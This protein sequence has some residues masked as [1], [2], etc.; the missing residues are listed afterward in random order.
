MRPRTRPSHESQSTIS[1]II[2]ER[3]GGAAHGQ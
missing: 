1:I 2:I 3:L